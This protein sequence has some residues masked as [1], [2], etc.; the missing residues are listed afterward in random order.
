MPAAAPGETIKRYKMRLS[1]DEYIVDLGGRLPKGAVVIVDE[2]TAI[3]W[4]ENGIAEQAPASAETH[5]Q[6][7]RAEIA[8]RLVPISE[9]DGDRPGVFSSM[10]GSEPATPPVA[11]SPTPPSRRSKASGQAEARRKLDPKLEG[12][13][14]INDPKDAPDDLHMH[15]DDD[16]DEDE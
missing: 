15:A 5:R 1:N 6:R 13:G 8:A 11:P 14:V 9:A 16:D 7:Q 2:D 10:M 12:A 3:R 4:L